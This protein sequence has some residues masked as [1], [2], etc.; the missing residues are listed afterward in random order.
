MSGILPAYTG[1]EY[2]DQL[3]GQRPT[4]FA[5]PT[6]PAAV[7]AAYFRAI[8]DCLA[9]VGASAAEL[10]NVEADPALAIQT[11]SDWET[12]FGLPDACTPLNPTIQQR[13]NALL[14][15]IAA[16]GGQSAD[17]FVNLCALLGFPDATI[18]T[19]RPFRA[20]VSAVG[21]AL[22]ADTA[23]FYWQ[24]NVPSAAAIE[25]FRA[26][27]S[28]IG[29][30]LGFAPDGQLGCILARYAPAHAVLLVNYGAA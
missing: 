2:G 9:A 6:D 24:I 11:L 3:L 21:D 1:D 20:G 15:R 23:E 5:W 28:A 7:Q 27:E 4:G 16:Q 8:G 19:F 14:A 30:S 22:Y 29:D 18:T 13:R 25:Y 12:A 17:Y 10:A 26:G